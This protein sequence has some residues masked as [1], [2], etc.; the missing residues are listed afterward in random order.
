M[1]PLLKRTTAGRRELSYHELQIFIICAICGRFVHE[2]TLR[3]SPQKLLLKRTTAGRRILSTTSLTLFE[4]L[5]S[6]I[7][8]PAAQVL[9][10]SSGTVCRAAAKGASAAMG[11]RHFFEAHGLSVRLDRRMHLA[12]GR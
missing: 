4:V 7:V 2:E 3:A 10:Q 11:S 8:L 1:K 12:F 6:M 9:H 5:L